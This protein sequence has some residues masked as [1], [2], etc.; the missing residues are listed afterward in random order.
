MIHAALPGAASRN[1]RKLA[2]IKVGAEGDIAES[3]EDAGIAESAGE[4]GYAGGFSLVRLNHR[5]YLVTICPTGGKVKSISDSMGDTE[6]GNS[7]S[8]TTR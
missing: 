6:V 5:S 4:T 2:S 1:I 7:D 3:L 8:C